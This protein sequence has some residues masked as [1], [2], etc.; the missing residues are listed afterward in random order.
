MLVFGERRRILA[1]REPVDMRKSFQGLVALVRSVLGE[2]PLSGTVFVFVNRRGNYVKLLTWD[3]TGYSLYAK[4]LER[5]RFRVPGSG[6]R[7]ELSM[8]A[9]RLFLDGIVLGGRMSA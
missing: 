8:V 7:T 4:K 1:W 9:L 6:E 3:R 2:D 5:G